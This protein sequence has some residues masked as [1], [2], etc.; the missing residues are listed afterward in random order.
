MSSNVQQLL[1][2]VS[3]THHS[4]PTIILAICMRTLSL[5]L[6]VLVPTVLHIRIDWSKTSILHS[7][8]ITCITTTTGIIT[9]TKTDTRATAI[10]RQ[11]ET[12]PT[13]LAA[14][15]TSPASTVYATTQHST[16]SPTAP[17]TQQST[18]CATAQ[19]SNASPTTHAAQSD[20]MYATTPDSHNMDSVSQGI[21]YMI[22]NNYPVHALKANPD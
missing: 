6:R 2:V 11:S 18:M 4:M 12:T 19:H 14:T 22:T 13:T 16:T 21:T 20:T 3:F 17:A 8:I 9:T 10:S 5:D 15:L 7:Y 1:L